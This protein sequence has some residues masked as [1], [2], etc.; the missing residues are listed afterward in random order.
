MKADLAIV[1]LIA[2]LPALG[3]CATQAAPEFGGR[4]RVANRFAAT[5][6]EIPLHRT[7]VFFASPLDETLRTMLQ[8]WAA[9]SQMV[10]SYEAGVD[11][12][13][14]APVSASH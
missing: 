2:V 8:R 3:G 11:Y 13:L 12:T 10:L 1:I 7:Y 5:T 6:Q 4:W 14:H 9:D